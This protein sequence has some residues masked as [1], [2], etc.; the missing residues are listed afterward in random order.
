MLLRHL[1][2]SFGHM[3]LIIPYTHLRLSVGAESKTVREK[4]KR[5]NSSLDDFTT[6]FSGFYAS[7]FLYSEMGR[8]EDV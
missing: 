2:Q 3:S 6:L 4:M 1:G 7:L 5:L 8:K